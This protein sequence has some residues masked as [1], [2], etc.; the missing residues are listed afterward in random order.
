VDGTHIPEYRWGHQVEDREAGGSTLEVT[1]RQSDAP[2]E[3]R[4]PV[5]LQLEYGDGT[6]EQ[7]ILLVDQPEKSFT[8]HLPGPPD[9]ITFNPHNAVLA[10]VLE[11]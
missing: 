5:P 1:V 9:R 4:M 10:R 3:F 11:E 6:R 7:L 8:F 2:D